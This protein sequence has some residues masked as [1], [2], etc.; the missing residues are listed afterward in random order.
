MVQCPTPGRKCSECNYAVVRGG[1]LKCDYMKQA[2]KTRQL[3]LVR[4]TVKEEGI[5]IIRAVHCPKTNEL[6]LIE[7]NCGTCPS[8]KGATTY[9]LRC[10]QFQ[11]TEEKKSG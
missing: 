2:K 10:T 8:Y 11:K 7:G 6:I 3:Q 5:P 4:E 9:T 1:K